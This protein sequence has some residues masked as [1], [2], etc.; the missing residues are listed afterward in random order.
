MKTTQSHEKPHILFLFSDTGGGHRSASNAIIEALDLEFPDQISAD[1]I[2][3]FR[4]YAPPPLDRA[5]EIY[6]PLT[7]IPDIWEFGFKI[8]DGPKRAHFI[9]TMVSPY[10]RRYVKKLVKEKPADLYVSVHPLTNTH[11]LQALEEAP[12]KFSTVVTDLVSAHAFWYD[13]RADLIIVGTEKARQRGLNLGIDAEKIKVIGLPVS[14]QF[15]ITSKD[16]SILRE[17]L[18][19]PSDKPIVLIVGGGDGMGPLKETAFAIDN[20]NVPCHLVIITGRN[21]QLKKQLENHSWQISTQIYGFVT[22]MPDFMGASNILVTKAGPGTISEAFTAG[23]P[24]ILYS[25]L[26]GQEEGNV[27]Y[28]VEENAG[29]WAPNPNQVAETIKN[30]VSNNN[31]LEEMTSRSKLLARPDA[32]RDIAKSLAKLVGIH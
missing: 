6:P 32:A 26:P 28:V 13:N 31:L 9:N 24:I 15:R 7:K 23:L 14:E 18:G 2:D 3:F 22:D 10:V 29:I 19:W 21:Q 25:R 5:P 16:K 17:K 8:S 20:N 11:I 4:E 12:I 27:D 1:M 30:W